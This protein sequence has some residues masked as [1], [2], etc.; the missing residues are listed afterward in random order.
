MVLI[1][2]RN[3][4]GDRLRGRDKIKCCPRRNYWFNTC[5]GQEYEERRQYHNYTLDTHVLLHD[6]IF[7]I[8]ARATLKTVFRRVAGTLL[9]RNVD[10]KSHC[11]C[12]C[13]QD[14][15]NLTHSAMKYLKIYNRR[16]A[17][18]SG[19]DTFNDLR[20]Y[21]AKLWGRE[22]DRALSSLPPR[23]CTYNFIRLV[24]H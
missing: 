14:L 18:L 23:S 21:F 13:H 15:G 11:Q 16:K 22:L 9:G 7:T 17:R 12:K 8:I 3:N 1:D 5:H 6:I 4:I 19:L 20:V 2:S 10:C 24:W